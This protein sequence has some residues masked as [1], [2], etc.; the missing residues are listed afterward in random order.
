VSRV[1]RRENVE[2]G[3]ILNLPCEIGG[4]PKT[5]NHTS[6]SLPGKFLTQLFKR[7]SEICGGGDDYLRGVLA[8]LRGWVL[9]AREE[10]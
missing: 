10:D 5:E 7:I 6:A 8:I 3:A 1:G 9:T 4:A 2:R